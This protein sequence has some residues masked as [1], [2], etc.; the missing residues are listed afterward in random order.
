MATMTSTKRK[1][2]RGAPIQ[3]IIGI[4]LLMDT[5][6]DIQHNNNKPNGLKQNMAIIRRSSPSHQ[7][8]SSSI[9]RQSMMMIMK[10]MA[11]GQP[12][13]KQTKN[14]KR[15]MFGGQTNVNRFQSFHQS[16]N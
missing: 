3:G 10:I 15:K 1:L 4:R 6:L 13:K 11:I 12:L 14:P 7:I 9:N 8:Q 2:N 5:Q 16:A